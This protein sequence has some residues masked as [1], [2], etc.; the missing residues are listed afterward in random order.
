[1]SRIFLLVAA[2]V[3][4]VLTLMSFT[5]G[6]L[7]AHLQTDLSDSQLSYFVMLFWALSFIYLITTFW[8]V[9]AYAAPSRLPHWLKTDNVYALLLLSLL[10]FLAVFPLAIAFG[11]IANF[12]AVILVSVLCG[13]A[14][15]ALVFLLERLEAEVADSQPVND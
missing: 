5:Y 1:M 6:S 12:A 9:T 15:V 13:L 11:F 7:T 10:G 3:G 2:F 4:A 8:A 14:P